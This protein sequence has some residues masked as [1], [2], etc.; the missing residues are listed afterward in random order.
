MVSSVHF[1]THV[2][3][4]LKNET[5]YGLLSLFFAGCPL[6]ADVML[7]VDGSGS[8]GTENFD[9]LI[10][11]VVRVTRQF[12]VSPERTHMGFIQFSERSKVEIGLGNIT[13]ERGFERAIGN[14][15]YQNGVFTNTGEAIREATD[16]LFDS[17]EARD[18][19]KLMFLFTDGVPIIP[20]DAVNAGDEAR[21]RG[22][23]ITAVGITII[24]G[25][26]AEFNLMDITGSDQRVFLVE[27]F[28]EEQLNDVVENLTTQA[29][30]CM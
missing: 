5:N 4:Y 3:F 8:I 12:D 15:V 24:P 30:F 29:C 25:S 6:I 13:D 26:I 27:T 10:N 19:S 20:S 11:F 7:V 18:V 14:I 22:I 21:R 1:T 23:T 17:P 9:T 2:T 28:N 16:Q